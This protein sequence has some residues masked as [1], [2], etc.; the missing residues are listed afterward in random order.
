MSE[1]QLHKLL[2]LFDGC[3]NIILNMGQREASGG[4]V[5]VGLTE[6]DRVATADALN[7]ACGRPQE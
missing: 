2:E 5:Y 4:E 6:P 1:E 7:I 3:Q